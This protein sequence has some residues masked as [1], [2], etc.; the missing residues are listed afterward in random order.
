MSKLDYVTIAI[1]AV[2]IA[3]II[4]LVYKTNKLMNSEEPGT[5][6]SSVEET[7]RNQQQGE[8]EDDMTAYR[9]PPGSAATDEEPAAGTGAMDDPDDNE[10]TP[11]DPTGEEPFADDAE[12]E[13]TPPAR[14]QPQAYEPP[15]PAR[16]PESTASTGGKYM[17]L[18][19]SFR[20]KANAESMVRKLKQLGFNEAQV[21]YTNNGAYAVA[22]VN[23]FDDLERARALVNTLKEQ[24]QIDAI[25]KTEE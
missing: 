8:E 14:E 20:Y 12:T 6:R 23:R 21:G 3:A 9:Q 11:Y 2:C 1:V 7:L 19:G 15:A 24:H 18:A 22:M 16:Q 17:V 10:V 13:S 4:F 25:V 5:N